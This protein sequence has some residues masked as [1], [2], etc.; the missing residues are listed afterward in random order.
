MKKILALGVVMGMLIAMKTPIAYAVGAAYFPEATTVNI[1]Q[2]A[3]SLDYTISAG[4]DADQFE[5]RTSSFIITISSGQRFIMTQAQ[6]KDFS[7]D[8]GYGV[9]CSGTST[10]TLDIVGPASQTVITVTPTGGTPCSQS[11]AGGGGSGSG[12]PAAT[13][14]PV[15]TPSPTP[16]PT[17]TPNPSVSATPTPSSVAIPSPLANPAQHGLTEGNVISAVTSDDPDVYIINEY[18]FKRLFLNVKIFSFYG[19]LGGFAKVKPV[20]TSTRDA[21]ITSGLF[22]N[23]ETNDPKVYGLEITAEDNGTL[24]WIDTTGIQAVTDD[25][26]F[27]KKVFCINTSEF[28][29]Y[30]KSSAYTSVLDIPKYARASGAV[31]GATTTT[32]G[33]IKIYDGLSWLNVRLTPSTNGAIVGKVLSGQEF[34]FLIHENGWYQIQKDGTTLGWVSG[35]YVSEL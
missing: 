32:L 6:G 17:N 19:H 4:S 35:Q 5:V 33:R 23:C 14:V 9:S 2:G 18:G 26:D 25:P 20:S 21:F 22:R 27:F 12:A 7:N 34:I 29:W 16:I 1:T 28:N 3:N 13:V 31:A 24:H 10:S 30:P 15:P 8:A 11:G